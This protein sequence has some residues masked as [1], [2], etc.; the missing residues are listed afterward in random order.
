VTDRCPRCE[1][2]D[3][4]CSQCGNTNKIATTKYPVTEADWTTC[5]HCNNIGFDPVALVEVL[6]DPEV[7]EALGA[8]RVWFCEYHR[9]WAPQGGLCDRRS[10]THTI[11]EA[12]CS[13]RLV[14]PLSRSED[15]K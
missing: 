5:D 7:Q 15:T 6:A 9:M 1:M 2:P 4:T 3:L 10:V 11:A 12:G 13:W 8:E 14:V